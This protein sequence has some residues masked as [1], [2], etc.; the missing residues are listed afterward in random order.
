MAD[1]KKSLPMIPSSNWWTL[2]KKFL[3]TLP[4]GAIDGKYLST[5]LGI[6]EPAAKNLIPPLKQIGLV[7]DQNKASDLA[8]KWR[9]NDTYAE[10]CKEML[11]SVYP[12]GLK[13]VQPGPDVD[14]SQAAT[15]ISKHLGVGDSAAKRMAA[16]YALI[17]E[18]DPAKESQ[19]GQKPQSAEGKPKQKSSV[20]KIAA[21]PK[22]VSKTQEPSVQI[23]EA[24]VP[25]IDPKSLSFN[26]TVHLDIQIHISPEASNDQIEKIFESMG[27]HLFNRGKGE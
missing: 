14:K 11:D 13:D 8:N 10:A 12:D 15:W 6:T 24:I 20:S 4:K 9:H 3:Q 23:K 2:R 26:P 18:A 22:G 27:K 1:E 5:L 17:V 7:D 19:E 21:Q 16:L 25:P